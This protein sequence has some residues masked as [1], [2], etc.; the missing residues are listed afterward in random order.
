L[1]KPIKTLDLKRNG[2]RKNNKKPRGGNNDSFSDSA[3]PKLVDEDPEMRL[4]EDEDVNMEN[5]EENSSI[6]NNEEGSY[7]E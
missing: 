1:S 2:K 3:F 4:D 7:N 5:D 6:F